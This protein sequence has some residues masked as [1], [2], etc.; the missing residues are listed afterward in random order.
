MIKNAN[1]FV[2]H[3]VSVQKDIL[4]VK[5]AFQELFRKK[6]LEINMTSG[7]SGKIKSASKVSNKET[8]YLHSYSFL[9]VSADQQNIP[10]ENWDFM[11]FHDNESKTLCIGDAKSKE[12]D[13]KDWSGEILKILTDKKV[14]LDYCYAYHETLAFGQGYAVG[15]FCEDDK[16]DITEFEVAE[17][18]SRWLKNSPFDVEAHKIR[19]VFDVNI[20]SEKFFKSISSELSESLKKT[21]SLKYLDSIFHMLTLNKQEKKELRQHLE[22]KHILIA[23]QISE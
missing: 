2:A 23:K 11:C 6:D 20:F 22:K 1:F 3:N 15:V 19:D 21:S 10:S 18:I 5:N 4:S 12:I 16:H 17:E 8:D 7:K 14:N 9:A 13:I